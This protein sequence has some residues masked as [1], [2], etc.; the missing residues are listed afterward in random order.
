MIHETD[1]P[2]FELVRDQ[3]VLLIQAILESETGD[4]KQNPDQNLPSDESHFAH[5]G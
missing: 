3:L 1:D 4:Q 5:T 2:E